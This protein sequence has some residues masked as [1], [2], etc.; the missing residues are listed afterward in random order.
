MKKLILLTVTILWY[1]VGYCQNVGI[2]T[3][4]P[5]ASAQLDISS[6]SKGVL[7]PRLTKAQRQLIATPAAGLLVYQ[8]APDSTAFIFMMVLNGPGL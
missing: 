4:T 3:I 1:V 8:S 5:D 7:L 2:G 6:T